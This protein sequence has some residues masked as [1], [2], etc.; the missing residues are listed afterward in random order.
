MER[1]LTFSIHK[2]ISMD[3]EILY[4]SNREI[5]RLGFLQD[6]DRL[7][8]SFLPRNDG[9]LHHVVKKKNGDRKFYE[10]EIFCL[11]FFSPRTSA[12]RHC[13]GA[14]TYHIYNKY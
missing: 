2:L 11:H 1:E 5:V 9:G 6:Q 4:Y 8:R 14:D 13:E 10:R 3:E 7:L 12:D